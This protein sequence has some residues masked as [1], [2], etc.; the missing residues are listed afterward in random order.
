MYHM[1]KPVIGGGNKQRVAIARSLV[2]DPVLILADEATGNLDT[3]TSYEIMATISR[4]KFKG[5]KRLSLSP[6]K[7][8]LPVSQHVILYSEM[9]TSFDPGKLPTD[10]TA[11]EML[12]NLPVNDEI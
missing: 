10:L 7:L 4:V 12:K 1:P 5:K 3:R 2:N 11:I 8:I 6:M 9:D